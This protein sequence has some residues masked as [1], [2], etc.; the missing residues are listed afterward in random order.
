MPANAFTL[1]GGTV[2]MTDAIVQAAADKG[3]SD[4]AWWACWPTRSAGGAPP[5]HAHGGGTRRA[6]HGPGAG[7]WAMCR[8][9]C[10]PAPPAHQ[11]RL[12]PQP[13][14]R[15]RLLRHRPHAPGIVTHGPMGQLL[16]AIAHDEE[17]EARKGHQAR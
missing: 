5:R 3:I 12:Q 8:A 2:V 7:L 16:L 14:A 1:P 17:D 6:E 9:W 11:P 15:G 4:D 13:R 10:P